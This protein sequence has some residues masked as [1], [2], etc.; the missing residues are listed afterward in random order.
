MRYV[1]WGT[2]KKG[3]R[4]FELLKSERVLAFIDGDVSKQGQYFEKKDILSYESYKKLYNGVPII[5]SMVDYID[6]EKKILSD[7]DFLPYFVLSQQPAECS[8]LYI[9]NIYDELPFK[10]D[11]N[12]PCI[13]YG[14][15]LVA[16]ELFS[17][18]AE[19]IRVY[20]VPAKNYGNR[21]REALKKMFPENYC[22]EIPQINNEHNLFLSEPL[23]SFKSLYCK[24][25]N[26]F[27]FSS[28]IA[29]YRNP[30]IAS[31]KDKYSK[32]RCFIVATGPSLKMEDLDTLQKNGEFC[33]SMN[34]IY[35]AFSYTKW[36]PDLY[37]SVDLLLIEQ[38]YNFIKNLDIPL[39]FISDLYKQNNMEVLQFHA[40]SVNRFDKN[41]PF[42]EDVSVCC[43]D[44][45]TITYI[46]LQFAAYM[47]FSEIYLLGVDFSFGASG[48][49][50]NHFYK[51]EAKKNN[52][53]YP[54]FCLNA[55]QAA[56]KYAD[57]HGIKIYN[58]T[59]GGK[60]EVF[61]RVDFDSLFP[62][63]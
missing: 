24:V 11:E 9:Q 40:V 7:N 49:P 50:G 25:Y 21:Q 54:D 8:F 39:K 36:R 26:L 31:L 32:K 59:R 46:C 57:A 15:N 44:A 33:I 30:H 48:Q 14:V 27:D 13:F 1:I 4:L 62:H 18:I 2:G 19:K 58:A 41:I 52:S 51:L 47:G 63:E 28:Q 23:E 3:G 60:L 37:L 34:R 16:A 56:K 29:S 42:S 45:G 6:V 53:F 5:I 61:P 38:F 20:I 35:E 22:E 12:L 17:R 10:F 55:Y 43:F